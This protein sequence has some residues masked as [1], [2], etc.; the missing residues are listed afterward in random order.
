MPILS[1]GCMEQLHTGNTK[2]L[3]LCAQ[4]CAP[5]YRDRGSG[6][7]EENFAIGEVILKGV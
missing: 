4:P 7:V 3:L 2:I 6:T 5:A 1:N